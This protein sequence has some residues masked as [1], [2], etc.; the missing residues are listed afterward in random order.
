MGSEKLMTNENDLGSSARLR[1][2][3]SDGRKQRLISNDNDDDNARLDELCG[4]L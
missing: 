4:Q 1:T 3:N 2:T